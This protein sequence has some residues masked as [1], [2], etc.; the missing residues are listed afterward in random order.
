MLSP[1]LT[2]NNLTAPLTQPQWRAFELSVAEIVARMDLDAVVR[3]DVTLTGKVSG[4]ARQVDVLVTGSIGGQ[5]M[6]IAIECEQ[7]TK[8]LG[9]GKIDEFSGKLV[10]LGVDCGVL[11]SIS[12][13]TA[14][15]KA[16]AQ[17]A[18]QP[19]IVLRPMQGPLLSRPRGHQ[20]WPN[21]PASGT[22]QTTTVTSGTSGWRDW[23]Q[24][25]GETVM[26]GV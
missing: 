13:A 23:I 12:G 24:Q 6:S 4:V 20:H 16:R 9:I 17:N 26:A 1:I 3:H 19:R 22:A 7:Y 5:T 18:V 21:S 2:A 25:S 11:Y 10:D 15:A 8:L 14:P